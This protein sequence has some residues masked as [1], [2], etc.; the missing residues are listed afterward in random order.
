M[1]AYF[2][3]HAP[4]LKKRHTAAKNVHG[5]YKTIDRVT[6]SLVSTPK[7]YIAD[8]KNVLD[9]VLDPG[10]TYRRSLIRKALRIALSP[11]WWLLTPFFITRQNQKAFLRIPSATIW[12]PPE[13]LR[14]DASNS[15]LSA[16]PDLSTSSSLRPSG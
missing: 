2:E 7:L 5:W 3:K 4:A 12:P 9:P 11:S 1:R 6:H 10:E 15:P 16:E 8:I 13:P 14:R